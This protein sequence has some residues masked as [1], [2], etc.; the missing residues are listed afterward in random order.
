MDTE[1][2]G[3]AIHLLAH[4]AGIGIDIDLGHFFM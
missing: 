1:P 3:D 2:P 4:R